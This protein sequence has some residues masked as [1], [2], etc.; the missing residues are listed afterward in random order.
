MSVTLP[1]EIYASVLMWLDHVTLCTVERVRVGMG[2]LVGQVWDQLYR[3]LRKDLDMAD[4]GC[5]ASR[6]CIDLEDGM[7]FDEIESL[8]PD[9]DTYSMSDTREFNLIKVEECPK[10]ESIV[11][12]SGKAHFKRLFLYAFRTQTCGICLLKTGMILRVASLLMNVCPCVVKEVISSQKIFQTYGL[13][14]SE[15]QILQLNSNGLI[16]CLKSDVCSYFRMTNLRFDEIHKRQSL[17]LE[18]QSRQRK[19]WIE[20]VKRLVTSSE[21]KNESL[22]HI[23]NDF[24]YGR[25]TASAVE[26]VVQLIRLDNSI[27]LISEEYFRVECLSKLRECLAIKAPT[28][29]ID[30]MSEVYAD[31]VT[32]YTDPSNLTCIN[33]FTQCLD[34]TTFTLCMKFRQ[35]QTSQRLHRNLI[36]YLSPFHPDILKCEGTILRY[37]MALKGGLVGLDEIARRIYREECIGR[38]LCKFLSTPTAESRHFTMESKAL[39]NAYVRKN[40][41][42]NKV[43][44]GVWPSNLD[45]IRVVMECCKCEKLRVQ[46]VREALEWCK[47]FNVESPDLVVLLSS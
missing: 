19:G 47:Y 21:L 5:R 33:H 39:I 13:H 8:V 32:N 12:R 22:V 28:I 3:R 17:Y 11:R 35:I 15:G 14:L 38:L 46:R 29:K 18:E 43:V 31:I 10:V 20:G 37:E 40:D 41:H 24:Q 16:L 23:L 45:M 2:H 27:N 25:C 1:P 6:D 42:L 9:M 4:E 36:L 30:L 7:V 34:Y 44:D 26:E